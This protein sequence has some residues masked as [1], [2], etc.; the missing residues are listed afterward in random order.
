[1]KHTFGHLSMH[2]ASLAANAPKPRG[3][4][5]TC[6]FQCFQAVL[7]GFL[8]PKRDEAPEANFASVPI[9]D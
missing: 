7:R 9:F 4:K 6:C 8:Q 1:M 5:L 2:Q 3:R